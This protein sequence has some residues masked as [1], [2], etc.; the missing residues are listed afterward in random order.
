MLK[1]LPG[2]IGNLSRSSRASLFRHNSV[3]FSIA[4]LD[5]RLITADRLS[6]KRL[7]ALVART[8]DAPGGRKFQWPE[9]Y[10]PSASLTEAMADNPK[11]KLIHD[12]A[13]AAK[14]YAWAIGELDRQRAV[15]PKEH[16]QEMYFV[17]EEARKECE[18]LRK[19]IAEL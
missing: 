4:K 19:A 3:D 15:L 16:Y 9:H 8:F 6:K 18:R 11:S 2:R 5:L 13:L 1:F 17:A 7:I 14:H 10:R 12:Y